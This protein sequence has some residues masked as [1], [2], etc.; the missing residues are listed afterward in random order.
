[1]DKLL[2]AREK[3]ALRAQ[4]QRLDVSAT[5]GKAGLTEN[6]VINLQQ[7]LHRLEL[8]KVRLPGNPKERSM[9]A[10]QITVELGAEFVGGTGFNYLF[11]KLRPEED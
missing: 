9:M 1:M 7:Q 5:V 10:D 3:K 4:G 8:I 11:W 6:V 2:T